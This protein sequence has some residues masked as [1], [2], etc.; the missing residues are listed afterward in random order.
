L[1]KDLGAVRIRRAED[2]DYVLP[3]MAV[4]YV[5]DC[6]LIIQINGTSRGSNKALRE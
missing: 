3:A 4:G 1:G 2:D 6:L 5:P